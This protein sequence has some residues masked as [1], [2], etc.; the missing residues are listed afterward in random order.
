MGAENP[1]SL[2]LGGPYLA[3]YFFS[4]DFFNYLTNEEPDPQDEDEFEMRR[5]QEKRYIYDL[6][7]N[8]LA[9]PHKEVNNILETVDIRNKN[10]K[11]NYY[12]TT[13]LVNN[14]AYIE[15]LE[16]INELSENDF[17][18][19]REK[20]DGKVVPHL[21]HPI[22][23]HYSRL[24]HD[25]SLS[26]EESIRLLDLI[27]LVFTGILNSTI[28]AYG[29]YI[30]GGE[31]VRTL[32]QMKEE[33]IIYIPLGKGL[34]LSQQIVKS[35]Q[36]NYGKENSLTRLFD[37]NVNALMQLST[38]RGRL[39]DKSTRDDIKASFA[40]LNNV[41]KNYAASNIYYMAITDIDYQ[42]NGGEK[43]YRMSFLEWQGIEDL[44]SRPHKSFD[45]KQGIEK[46]DK[47][48]LLKYPHEKG[49][50]F[51]RLPRFIIYA[52]C[53]HCLRHHYY[54][55]DSLRLVEHRLEIQLCYK[56]R[57]LNPISDQCQDREDCLKEKKALSR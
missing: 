20:F 23:I 26:R 17:Q 2:L 8:N 37:A 57:P 44:E 49:S 47:Q 9:I 55:T 1:Q 29:K 32:R 39:N 43:S 24:V 46:S 41:I 7:Q 11:I 53:G 38:A 36:N 22:A 54:Y 16:Q 28:L 14:Q 6:L 31:F 42:E 45:A 10:E 21:P 5:I 51:L 3:R 18:R 30:M 34:D 27:L 50:S 13:E 25:R 35:L 33:D 40:K 48:L 4:T 19:I 15:A 56:L 52:K 12:G